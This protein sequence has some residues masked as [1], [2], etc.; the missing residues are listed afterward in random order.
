MPHQSYREFQFQEVGTSFDFSIDGVSDP[1]DVGEFTNLGLQ[2]VIV[3]NNRNNGVIIAQV[4][5]DGVTF[6]DFTAPFAVAT[7]GDSHTWLIGIFSGRWIRFKLDHGTNTTGT[8]KF[9]GFG[10]V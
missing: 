8:V 4:S 3:G 10:K 9:Y 7:G 2:A 5:L 1:V 6:D